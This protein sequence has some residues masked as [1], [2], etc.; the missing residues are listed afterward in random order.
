MRFSS[1]RE[2]G[3]RP[4]VLNI[5]FDTEEEIAVFKAV[6]DNI[7]GDPAHTQRLMFDR[8]S[9]HLEERHNFREVDQGPVTWGKITIPEE[10]ILEKE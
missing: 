10:I 4:I 6:L 1:K 7:G 5:V 3:F 8:I 9:D 2:N